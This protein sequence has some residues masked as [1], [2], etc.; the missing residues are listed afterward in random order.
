MPVHSLR[1]LLG[2]VALVP[3]AW[4]GIV[5]VEKLH[6]RV[7]LLPVMIVWA[8]VVA[9]DVALVWFSV[10]RSRRHRVERQP[11]PMAGRGER[12]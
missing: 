4:V 5:L 12:K 9:A 7:V 3:L 6:G 2:G 10:G 1:A 11:E 8:L